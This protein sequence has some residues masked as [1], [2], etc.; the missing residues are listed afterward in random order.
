MPFSASARFCGQQSVLQIAGELD[1]STAGRVADL[2]TEALRSGSTHLVVDVAG[3]TFMDCAALRVLLRARRAS[4]ARG[5]QLTLAAVPRS[6]RALLAL[7]GAEELI[8]PEQTPGIGSTARVHSKTATGPSR[9]ARP[10]IR[11]CQYA[12]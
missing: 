5:G 9:Y 4:L 10:R 7:T 8:G 6:V 2:I 1:L 11:T 12:G 3:V